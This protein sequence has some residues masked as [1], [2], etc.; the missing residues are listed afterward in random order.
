MSN[1]I[2]DRRPTE[3]DAVDKSV[4][5]WN[6]V[7]NQAEIVLYTRIEIGEPWMPIERPEP[8]V[9]SKRYEVKETT[10]N[11]WFVRHIIDFGYLAHNLPTREAAERVAAI[12]EE[13]M[14]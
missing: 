14:P 12:Y 13:V 1:W 5:W 8:Y 9:K 4:I 7:F 2:T 3:K 11:G 10:K 6:E